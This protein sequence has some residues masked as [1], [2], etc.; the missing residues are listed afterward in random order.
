[1]DNQLPIRKSPRLKDYDYSQNGAYFITICT[2]RREHSFGEII[3][4]EM[5]L[6]EM[7]KIAHSCWKQVPDHFPQV[8]I[9]AFIV[10]PNHV[11][12]IILIG[13]QPAS[14]T[15][16]GTRYASSAPRPNGAKSGSLGAIIGSYKSAVTK[17]IR[18]FQK[19]SDTIIWQERYH[20]HII[21]NIES[22]DKIRAYTVNNPALWDKDT[23]FST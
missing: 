14:E 10:M 18:D 19:T 17:Q 8:E 9:D 16:V 1:M 3:D 21:R 13:D 4:D 5:Y 20:D 11:H 23:F 2:Y 22:L 15:N 7:G 6:S 12:G